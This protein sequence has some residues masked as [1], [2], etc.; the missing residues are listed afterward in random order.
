M[1]DPEKVEEKTLLTE[2]AA[3]PT[4]VGSI[5]IHE[6]IGGME[7]E[8]VE[9]AFRIARALAH[10]GV[11]VPPHCREQPD[12]VFAILLQ[13]QEWGLPYMA[14]LNKSYVTKGKGGVERVAYEAQLVHTLIETRAKLKKMLRCE[15]KGEGDEMT[16]TV[17]GTFEGEDDPHTWESEKLGKIKTDIGRNEQGQI[18]GSPLW[19]SKPKV[20]LWYNTARDWARVHCPWVIL[21]VYT[22]DEMQDFEDR[23]KDVTPPEQTKLINAL[24]TAKKSASQASRGFDADHVKRE[25]ERTQNDESGGHGDQVRDRGQPPDGEHHGDV[26]DS[27]GSER[28]VAT[29]GETHA[30]VAGQES[31]TQGEIIPPPDDTSGPGATQAQRRRPATRSR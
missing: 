17:I 15:Y 1:V 31:A 14:V 28:T 8:T 12:T 24:Q 5:G 25:T 9:Q 19:D 6:K 29:V 4:K 11:A 13:A 3:L 20:Q 23:M 30:P 27:S 26:G 2:T 21:G 7:I 22:P 10:S 16:C 18:K